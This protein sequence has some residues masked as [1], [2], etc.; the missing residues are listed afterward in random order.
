MQGEREKEKEK[1][2][3]VLKA[4]EIHLAALREELEAD[5]ITLINL[6]KKMEETR[7]A[8]LRVESK[9]NAL[10]AKLAIIRGDDSSN[11]K[12]R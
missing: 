3:A 2:G 6:G 8:I 7:E 1:V 5:R 10:E 12:K 4:N 9:I 11:K